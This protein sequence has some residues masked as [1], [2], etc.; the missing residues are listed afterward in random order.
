M[1]AGNFGG[2]PIPGSDANISMSTSD[3]KVVDG[4]LPV[5]ITCTKDDPC[6]G[7]ILVNVSFADNAVELG[8][9]DL[10]V[11]GHSTRVIAVIVA[12]DILQKLDEVT[13]AYA[14]IAIDYGYPSCP[15]SEPA[16]PT[17]PAR[18]RLARGSSSACVVA[19]SVTIYAQ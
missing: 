13:K 9:S 1:Q 11:P 7:W 18:F 8:R 6:Q 10:F 4:M 2:V 14:L 15:G 12:K 17:S 19:A 3:T 5:T 16:G